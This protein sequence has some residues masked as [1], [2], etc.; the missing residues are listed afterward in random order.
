[1]T[2][3]T[4]FEGR[5]LRSWLASL[6]SDPQGALNDLLIGAEPLGHL[7]AADVVDV[8]IEWLDARPDVLPRIDQA[9][10]Q[11]IESWWGVTVLPGMRTGSLT[12]IVWCRVCSLIAEAR[13]AHSA[14]VLKP[15]VTGSR[16]FLSA[17]VEGRSRDPEGL[18]WLA[19]ARNQEDRS[20]LDH[21]WR[22]C[23]LP[24]EEPWYRADYGVHGLRGLPAASPAELGAFR[25]EVAEGVNRV[26]NALYKRAAQGALP[27]RVAKEEFRRIARLTAA[28]YPFEERWRAFWRHVLLVENPAYA[29]W[30][31]SIFNV[32]RPQ[33]GPQRQ[34][35]PAPSLDWADRAR[36][37]ASRL[38]RDGTAEVLHANQLLKEQQEYASKTGNVFFLAR[39]ATNFAA[40]IRERNPAQAVEWAELS[41]HFDEWNPYTWTIHVASLRTL[42][43]LED[44][45]RVA[46]DAWRR[47]P[48][49]VAVYVELGEVLLSLGHR[50]EGLAILKDAA[51][52]FPESATALERRID[53][54]LS[55][56]KES[57][58]SEQLLE[59]ADRELTLASATILRRAAAQKSLLSD[60]ALRRLQSRAEASLK[61]WV[62]DDSRVAAEL[63]FLYLSTN[64]IDAA[65]SLLRSASL[66]FPGSPR[67]LLARGQT[68][69]VV[70][71]LQGVDWGTA[72]QNM[73][74]WRKLEQLDERFTPVTRLGEARY[75]LAAKDG[76]EVVSRALDGL[77][78]LQDWVI[79][80]LKPT[81]EVESDLAQ[82]WATRVR[83]VL[84][85]S[86]S[87]GA[88]REEELEDIRKTERK[89][90]PLL[91]RLEEDWVLSMS[92]A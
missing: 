19:L 17:L 2:P 54:I 37:L 82:W 59:S 43:K 31:T 7:R 69:R 26:A 4:A 64:S 62:Q 87:S 6:E 39:S 53:R 16:G 63:G 47:F 58:P 20:L 15:L 18:A 50:R 61:N 90:T 21:W 86:Y 46:Q 80:H 60:E 79:P 78:R 52:R 36:D 38:E 70:G 9:V 3:E 12:A 11:W 28:A 5:I 14:Q 41:R 91:N 34:V 75:W 51:E 25:V 45:F 40:R 66:R 71:N 68:A 8:V 88:G 65:D 76:A 42:G 89:Q 57:R 49:N 30:F 1:M 29:E 84:L 24:L 13:L 67:V 92:L 48:H 56:D 44:A 73:D 32:T 22:L 81:P 27:E 35:L 74:S 55:G 77:D 23:N 33:R 83:N 72:Q 85:M 10:G